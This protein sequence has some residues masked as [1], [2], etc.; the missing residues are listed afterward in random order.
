M[1]KLPPPK[2]IITASFPAFA[3]KVNRIKQRRRIP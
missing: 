2:Q 1:K 3:K